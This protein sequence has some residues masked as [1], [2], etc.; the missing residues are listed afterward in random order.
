MNR[1]DVLAGEVPVCDVLADVGCDHGNLAAICLKTGKAKRVILTDVSAPS[2]EKAKRLL[3][4]EISSGKA[5]AVHCD[6]LCGVPETPDV[7]VIAGM[8][9][10][11]IMGILCRA[12]DLPQQLVLSPHK[13]APEL[14]EY[15]VSAGYRVV[16]D[17]VTED[18]G[19]YYDVIVCR[20]GAD[21]L[22]RQEIQF[23]RTNLQNK[24]PVFLRRIKEEK[25]NI[26]EYLQRPLSE[27]NREKL[28][29]RKR[30]LEEILL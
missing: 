4:D 10:R 29:D 24:T 28:L 14:R 25:Q 19:K 18:G 1:I 27:K 7:A 3:F 17:Y 21:S 23:G 22:S 8:G 5:V 26:E 9:G 16:R 15:V 12:P 2:L 13:N 30:L 6:G 20:R 11:E